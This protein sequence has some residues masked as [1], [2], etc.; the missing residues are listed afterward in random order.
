M[1]NEVNM[2][3]MIKSKYIK[4]IEDKNF[5]INPIFNNKSSLNLV[6]AFNNEYAKYFA[7]A[8]QSL[9]EN[10]KLKYL[11]DI[12]IFTSDLSDRNAKLLLKSIPNNF[13]IRFF[14]I[15]KYIT[16]YFDN[17]KLSTKSYWSEEIYYR[18]FIPIIMNQYKKALYLDS[19]IIFNGDIKDL[20]S[21]DFEGKEIIAI[22]DTVKLVIKNNTL[23]NRLKYIKNDLC[24][25]NT[26]QYFNSGVLLF[27]IS[28]IN[29]DN[30]KQRFLKA[31]NLETLYY[32]DQDML[33]LIFNNRV[34]LV[35]WKWNLQ[36]HIPIYHFKDIINMN[37]KEYEKYL[38]AF[39]NPIIVHYTSPLKPWADST[40]ELS[41]LFWIYARKTFYYEEILAYM[42]KYSVIDTLKSLVLY[43]KL[44]D[45]RK[46]VLWGASIFLETFIKQYDIKTDNIIGIIDK[47]PEKQGTYIEQYKCYAPEDIIKLKPDEIIITIVNNT[48]EREKEIKLF[49]H[50]K[51]LE[52]IKI[53]RLV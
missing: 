29:L 21:Y 38:N 3:E 24:I 35:D 4:P 36:Y 12:V 50:S 2:S 23:K 53:T 52:N 47:N 8:L 26:K 48:D 16:T 15:K 7:V 17:I 41:E 39:E 10:S 43:I 27:N 49:L 25:K 51:N 19:D 11:Y 34:K 42:N 5:Q 6:F 22:S 30:Y 37:K 31:I 46:I 28:E 44:L 1:F 33:N 45:N 32:P 14:N 18:I 9:I 13:S 40:Q 20:F